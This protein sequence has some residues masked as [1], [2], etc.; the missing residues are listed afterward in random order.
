MR[1]TN[2]ERDIHTDYEGKKGRK[3]WRNIKE[4]EL[5]E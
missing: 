5:G 3:R 1:D 4:I 2:K